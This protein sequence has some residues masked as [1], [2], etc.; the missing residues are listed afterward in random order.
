VTVGC[1]GTGDRGRAVLD[2]FLAQ[3]D[4]QVVAVCDVKTDQLDLSRTHVNKRYQN[5]D[6]VT[7]SDFRE[8]VARK[9]IDACLI[10]TPDHWHVLTA[11]SAVQSGKDVYLEKPM[12]LSL[13]EDWK[14]EEGSA[15]AQAGFSI[16][17]A[18]TLLAFV[19][20]CV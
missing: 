4:V 10:A 19:S 9:D 11:L 5:Q 15:P 13:T 8:I 1:I 7:Y 20:L 14:A 6:C 3:K 2:G 17:H 16:W 12:G 18:A